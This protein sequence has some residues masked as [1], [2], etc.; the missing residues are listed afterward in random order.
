MAK[1]TLH[2]LIPELRGK[3]GNAVVRKIRGKYYM[4]RTPIASKKPT[5]G[6]KAFRAR[7]REASQYA[8][9]VQRDAVLKAFYEPIARGLDLRV[10]AVAISD[11]F[12]PPKIDSMDLER[13]RGRVGDPIIV[14]ASAKVGVAS[15]R[16]RLTT[17]THT[18][19]ETGEATLEAGKWHYTATKDVPPGTT[20]HIEA[21]ARNR[22]RHPAILQQT[23]VV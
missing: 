5:A 8:R 21:L 22:P 23:C 3:L 7:F 1:L 19:I 10:R 14:H 6:Q 17:A 2:E 15:V 20:V 16:L 11:W 4:S 9:H 18:L 12:N 13:Y